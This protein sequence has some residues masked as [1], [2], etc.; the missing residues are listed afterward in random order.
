MA[1][2][3][4]ARKE[5]K[6][7]R[8]EARVPAGLKAEL[9]RAAALQGQTLTDFVLSATAKAARRIIREHTILEL[10]RRDQMAFA[11]ALLDPPDATPKLAEAARRY[12]DESSG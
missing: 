6:T 2:E 9:L 1:T 10:C 7:D 3:S 4:T 8:L 12:R 11:E 5:T